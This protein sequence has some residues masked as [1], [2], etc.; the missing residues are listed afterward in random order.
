VLK[1]GADRR[2]RAGHPWVYRGEIADLAGGWDA[3]SVVDVVDA[4]GRFVGRGFYNPRPSLACRVLT[5]ADEAVDAGFFRRRL[6]AA[7]E[8]RRS[9]GL[10]PGSASESSGTDPEAGGGEIAYR[11]CWSEADGL[12]G[13]VVDRYGPVS[14]V[15]CLTLGMARAAPWVAAA[16]AQLFPGGAIRRMDDETAARI[17]GFEPERG[18]L[19][20]PGTQEIVISEDG[21][22]F[23]VGAGHKTG[24]YLDQRENRAQAA[25]HAPGR[26]VLDAFCYTGAFACHA[27]RA[28]AAG[29]LLLESSAEALALARQ[30][31]ALNGVADRALVREGNAFDTLRELEAAGERFG[32]VVLDPPP[33]TRRKEAVE[34]A[35]RGYK[36]IN[37]RGLK[38]LEPGGVLA[39]FSCSHHVTPALFEEICRDAAG[40]ARVTVR[41]LT[42]LTQSRDHPILLAVP[43]SRYL[44]GLLLQRV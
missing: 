27:L 7:L 16:L 12:P 39:T 35:A 32:L 24:F 31:L 36:E 38:L 42:P 29:A 19:G 20:E 41:V 3:G 30:N 11:L 17:E 9:V 26:R 14:V 4:G 1:R 33:F 40:D 5:R 15:Q 34:A 10:A 23:A 25:R 37:L 28:G 18:W 6:E 13:L 44:T 43:E 8:Y 21:C 2:L 22:R